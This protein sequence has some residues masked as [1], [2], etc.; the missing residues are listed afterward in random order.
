MYVAVQFFGF[1]FPAWLTA[2]LHFRRNDPFQ[3]MT[4]VLNDLVAIAKENNVRI[5]VLDWSLIDEDLWDGMWNMG[6]DLGYWFDLWPVN[7]TSQ[8]RVM[9]TLR[10]VPIIRRRSTSSLSA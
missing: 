7:T 3:F 4:Q 8:S 5:S 10:D 2:F 1:A 9:R 6:Q